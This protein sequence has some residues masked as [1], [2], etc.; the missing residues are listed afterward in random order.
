MTSSSVSL[1][2]SNHWR[3]SYWWLSRL[4]QDF[5]PGHRSH[6]VTV[7]CLLK[8]HADVSTPVSHLLNVFLDVPVDTVKTFSWW[9]KTFCG[10]QDATTIFFSLVS[11]SEMRILSSGVCGVTHACCCL[12]YDASP[13]LQ[14]SSL[15]SRSYVIFHRPT[16]RRSGLHVDQGLTEW[17]CLL[18]SY[19]QSSLG[20]VLS[21]FYVSL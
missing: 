19:S 12:T 13:T 20:I 5:V 2:S 9:L 15:T 8:Y 11:F 4:C 18:L 21:A 16:L 14:T 10:I 6:P 17:R 7:P 3:F 1:V